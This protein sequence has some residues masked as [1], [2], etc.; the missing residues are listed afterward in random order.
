[1]NDKNRAPLIIGVAVLVIIAVA[2]L[3]VVLSGGGDSSD[4]SDDSDAATSDVTALPI[5][6]VVGETLP[7]EV[8]G[9]PLP[10]LEDPSNDPTVGT[11]APVIAGQTFD[12]EPITIG[13]PTDSPTL[14]V[15]L[16]HWCPHCND[17]I[18][19]LRTLEAAGDIPADLAVVGVSTAAAPDRENYPPSQWI[20]DKGWPWPTLV[21]DEASGSFLAYGGSSFPFLVLLD[22]DGNVI[23]RKSG[24]SPAAD[25]K[26]WIDTSLA[27]VEA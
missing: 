8:T 1:M 2:G 14:A 23:A 6:D 7:I 27:T 3:A 13:G 21:D 25:I 19:E 5:G 15:F 9:G 22:A 24:Q 16:A 11:A 26:E 18:P 4:D 17:E 20:V 10:T 12:G